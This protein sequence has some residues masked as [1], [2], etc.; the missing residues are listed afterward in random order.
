[1]L[2]YAVVAGIGMGAFN[3]V[4]QALNVE[5]LPSQENAAKDLGVLNLAN[6]GGQIVGPLV[7]A[8]AISAVGYQAMFPF[9]AGLA[10]VGAGLILAIR[11]VR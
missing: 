11:R 7:A 1:M 8:A 4:D 6:T 10:L 3:A 9:A 2:A 5:V